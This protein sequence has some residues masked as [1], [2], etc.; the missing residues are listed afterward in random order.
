MF[1]LGLFLCFAF[2]SS[3]YVN[4]LPK[5]TPTEIA[6]LT[7]DEVENYTLRDTEHRLGRKMKWHERLAF[8]HAK[9]KVKKQRTKQTEVDESSRVDGLAIAGFATAIVGLF[10]ATL[11]LSTV[12]LIFCIIALSN[13]KRTGRKGRGLAIAGIVLSIIGLV[14]ILIALGNM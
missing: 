3:A 6:D 1:L 5:S 11:V 7:A 10:V 13:I 4:S 2:E 14:I 8:K 9:R 12:A